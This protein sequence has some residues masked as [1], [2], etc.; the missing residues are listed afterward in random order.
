MNVIITGAAGGL[1]RAFAVE[2]AKRG[3]DLF[4][5]D[6]DGQRLDALQDGLF[7]QYDVKA[8]TYPCDITDDDAVQEML[9]F[10]DK[11]GIRFDMLLNVAGVDF[12]GG[13]TVRESKQVLDIVK[14]NVEATL[15]VTHNVLRHRHRNLPF[16]IVFVS[17]LASMYPVPLKATY[18]ASKR[19]LLDFSIALGQELKSQ[20]VSVLS[21]CPGGLPTTPEALSGIAAQGFWGNATTNRLEAVAHRTITRALCKKRIYIPGIVNR[22]FS[23]AGKLVPPCIMARFLHGRWEKAQTKWLTV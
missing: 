7:R 13:F 21:L 3:Y 19:F 2:C 17:S 22:I 5:T 6:I 15:R 11:L 20:N 14:L 18:A 4:L 16:Y 1:G 9:S 23:I 12:E 8:I 10:S